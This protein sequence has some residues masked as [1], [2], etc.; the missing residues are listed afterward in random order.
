MKEMISL[1]DFVFA[2]MCWSRHMGSVFVG[3]HETAAWLSEK[4]LIFFFFFRMSEKEPSINL[5]SASNGLLEF[6]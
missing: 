2:L 6:W 3:V 4:E 1:I 5:S